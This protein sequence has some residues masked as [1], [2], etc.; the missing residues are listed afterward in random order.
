[1]IVDLTDTN[2]GKINDALTQARHAA[3]SPTLGMVLTLIVITDEDGHYDALQTAHESGREHPSRILTIV[4]RGGDGVGDGD[5]KHRLD[6]EVRVGGESG[7]GET[8][9]MRLYGELADHPASVVTPLLLP[10]APV[11][12]WWPGAAP[13]APAEDPIGRLAQRRITD[14]S[15]DDDPMRA[16][17]ARCASYAPGDTDLAWTRATTWRTILAASLDQPYDPISSVKVSSEDGNS[18]G[19]LLAAWLGS[20]LDVPSSVQSSPGPGI[21]EVELAMNGSSILLTRPDGRLAT[22][23]RPDQPDRTVAL[24]RRSLPELLTEELRRLDPDEVYAETL[25]AVSG[26][27]PTA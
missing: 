7:P 19:E 22:L 4:D 25:H 27:G 16:L 12:A 8:V 17:R 5:G 15:G 13:D 1:M 21:T 6:A 18:T 2:A 11:V 26:G 10:D 20:R 14:S 3:G 23:S 9:L 24:P